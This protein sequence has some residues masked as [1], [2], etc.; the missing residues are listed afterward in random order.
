MIKHMVSASAMTTTL[1]IWRQRAT[2]SANNS[3]TDS[4][5]WAHHVRRRL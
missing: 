3:G 4:H 1:F 2:L 5:Q